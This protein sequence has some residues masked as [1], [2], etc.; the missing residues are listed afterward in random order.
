MTDYKKLS[1]H[2]LNKA[3][4][5]ACQNGN[6]ELAKYLIESNDLEVHAQINHDRWKAIKLAIEVGQLDI[7]KYFLDEI[8]NE[9][10]NIVFN[11]AS[12][13]GQVEILNLLFTNTYF[14]ENDKKGVC[15]HSL[16]VASCSGKLNIFEYFFNSPELSLLIEKKQIEEFFLTSCAYGHIN[17]MEYLLTLNSFKQSNNLNALYN[18]G[19]I[20]ACDFDQTDS[21]KYLIFNLNMNLSSE[22]KD[23]LT[24]AGREDI[25]ELFNLRELNEKLHQNLETNEQLTKR[26]KL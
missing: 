3:L 4:I 1:Q 6:L 2:D 19:M 18:K 21:M 5:N 25:K 23:H 10:P 11:A 16:L 14:L 22:T 12:Q 26:I 15:Y 17:I 20:N 24:E 9:Y 8:Q 7:V 13:H